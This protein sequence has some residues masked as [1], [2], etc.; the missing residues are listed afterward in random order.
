MQLRKFGFLV[1]IVV[2]A[3]ATISWR[4]FGQDK[5]S[6]TALA[7]SVQVEIPDGDVEIAYIESPEGMVLDLESTDTHVQSQRFYLGDGKKAVLFEANSKGFF[8]PDGQIH[9]AG[10]KY[11]E[12]FS[13]Q[14]SPEKLV[15]WGKKRGEVYVLTPGLKLESRKK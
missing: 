7:S 6:Q 2:V 10:V 8:G 13:L 5:P 14:V 1:V 15:P 9:A 4:G 11:K 12:G 3:L